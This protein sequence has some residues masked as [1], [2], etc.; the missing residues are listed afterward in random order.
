VETGGSGHRSI[1]AIDI[2]A[3]KKKV[4][5]LCSEEYSGEDVYCGKDGT[6]LVSADPNV[7]SSAVA[8]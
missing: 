5:P 2:K 8:E 6:L 3:Q 4:C 7:L 1:M